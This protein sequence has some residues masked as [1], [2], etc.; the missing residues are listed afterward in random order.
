MAG[1]RS[2]YAAALPA[3]AVNVIGRS[4]LRTQNRIICVRS[5]Q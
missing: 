1:Q 3:A 2:T 4:V 5:R